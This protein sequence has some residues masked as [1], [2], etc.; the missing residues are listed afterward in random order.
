MGKEINLEF[1]KTE[2]KNSKTFWELFK[3]TKIGK[4]RLQKIIETCNIDVSHFTPGVGKSTRG[5]NSK[6]RRECP[7]CKNIFETF[8]RFKKKTCSYSC[9]NTYFRASEKHPNWKPYS[10]K[11]RKS[12]I[13][14]R[15]CLKYHKKECII[16]KESLVIDIHHYDENCSNN[17][18]ENLIPLC[19]TH[20]RYMHT[21]EGKKLIKNQVDDYYNSFKYK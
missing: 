21:N 12:S 20:H 17:L 18:P 4:K 16:C 9:A 3:R 13:A 14:K 10:E 8:K 5:V 6:E 1:I 11:P 7:V 2:V 15:I 19:P